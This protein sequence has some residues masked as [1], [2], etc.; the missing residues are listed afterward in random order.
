MKKIYLLSILVVAGLSIYYGVFNTAPN[1]RPLLN[2]AE[3]VLDENQQPSLVDVASPVLAEHNERIINIQDKKYQSA[4]S[5]LS[6]VV[7][8][9]LQEQYHHTEWVDVMVHLLRSSQHDQKIHVLYNLLVSSDTPLLEK[10]AILLLL[11][12]VASPLALERVVDAALEQSGAPLMNDFLFVIATMPQQ[13]TTHQPKLASPLVAVWE[14]SGSF[15]KLRETVAVALARVGSSEAAETLLSEYDLTEAVYLENALLELTNPGSINVFTEHL[16]TE[17]SAFQISGQI[18]ANMNNIKATEALFVWS[19][20]ASEDNMSD[21][22]KWFSSHLAI[23]A[24]SRDWLSKQ[25]PSRKFQSAAV[26]NALT[27]LLAD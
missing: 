16:R 23:Q 4:I 14:E 24:G 2:N 11:R 18:L 15:P 25:V 3:K 27:K 8:A 9:D 12:L 6:S 10:K 20:S 19:M 26:K 5:V 7:L 17:A 21:V 1:K 13:N 22:S